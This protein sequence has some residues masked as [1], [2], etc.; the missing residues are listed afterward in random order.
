[1]AIEDGKR[2][3]RQALERRTLEFA[4]QVLDFVLPLPQGPV[5]DVIGRQMLRSAT[6][7]G[8]NYREANRAASRADFVSK[9]NIAEKEASETVYWLELCGLRSLGNDRLRPILLQEGGELLA[10]LVTIGKRA[11]SK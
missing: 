5:R 4:A 10:I 9:V 7:I 2:Q 6:S 1:M 8:A 11:K 3:R